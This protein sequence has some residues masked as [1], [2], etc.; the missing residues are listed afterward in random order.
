MFLKRRLIC[1]NAESGDGIIG[2]W[3][4]VRGLNLEQAM[5]RI[6]LTYLNL[7]LLGVTLPLISDGSANIKTAEPTL[8]ELMGL[9]K[10]SIYKKEIHSTIPGVLHIKIVKKTKS[11]NSTSETTVWD[12]VSG[13]RSNKYELKIVCDSRD[14]LKR[15]I[16]IS[17]IHEGGGIIF[18][19]A[20]GYSY[21]V[22]SR[23][24]VSYR[25]YNDKPARIEMEKVYKIY[26][27][28]DR[29]SGVEVDHE[30]WIS[31]KSR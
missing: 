24:G 1:V 9:L 26:S 15:T 6:S 13:E 29:Y 14:E 31:L 8:Q 22:H 17:E 30:V 5:R 28:E 3:Y 19:A 18:T 21:D 2:L 20:P 11:A 10:I 23:S 16:N 12:Y 27:V 25:R 4:K 7:I